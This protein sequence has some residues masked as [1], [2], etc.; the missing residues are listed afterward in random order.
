MTLITNRPAPPLITCT[1]PGQKRSLPQRTCI[2]IADTRTASTQILGPASSRFT[3]GLFFAPPGSCPLQGNFPVRPGRYGSSP[4]SARKQRAATR[5][6]ILYKSWDLSHPKT[7]LG[8]HHCPT[9]DLAR[10]RPGWYGPS[11]RNICRQRAAPRTT[12]QRQPWSLPPPRANP[13]WPILGPVFASSTICL[14][15][16]PGGMVPRPVAPAVLN[17]ASLSRPD[18]STYFPSTPL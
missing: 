9:A 15:R 8:A 4:A 14:A 1:R 16:A 6:H 11:P 2:N 3:T 13:P 10:T 7:T 5:P 18:P 12:V 17:T